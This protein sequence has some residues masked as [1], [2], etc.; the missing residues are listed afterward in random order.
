MG[1]PFVLQ[2]A[3]HDAGVVGPVPIRRC[4]GGDERQPQPHGL[5]GRLSGTTADQR[6]RFASVSQQA[7]ANTSDQPYA[8]TFALSHPIQS[9]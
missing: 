2:V 5:R 9:V 1:K 7:L 8:L 3:S 6:D 4:R